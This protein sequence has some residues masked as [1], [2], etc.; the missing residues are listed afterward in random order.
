MNAATRARYLLLGKLIDRFESVVEN[1]G[2]LLN[3]W[4]RKEYADL[5][6]GDHSALSDEDFDALFDNAWS[7]MRAGFDEIRDQLAKDEHA[8]EEGIEP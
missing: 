1:E 3:D 8:D 2:D 7:R 4:G 5:I 6:A